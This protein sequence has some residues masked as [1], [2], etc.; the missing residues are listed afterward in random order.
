MDSVVP[1]DMEHL[2]LA[3]KVERFQS[4]YISG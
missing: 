3:F 2:T 1:L 4:C